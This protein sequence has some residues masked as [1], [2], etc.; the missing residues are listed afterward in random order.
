MLKTVIYY[1]IL[2]FFIIDS[3]L[4]IFLLSRKIIKKIQSNIKREKRDLFVDRIEKYLHQNGKMKISKNLSRFEMNLMEEIIFE[5]LTYSK[6]DMK[7]AIIEVAY[8]SGIVEKQMHE[9]KKRNWWSQ[10]TAAHRLG[11]LKYENAVPILLEKLESK[12]KEI[13]FKSGEAIIRITGA[14]HLEYV[15]KCLTNN[16]QKNYKRILDMIDGINQD[17]YSV[18]QKKIDGDCKEYIII[19]L[20]ALAKRKDYRIVPY[21]KKYLSNE[22]K[23]IRIAALKAS[24][25]IGD[26]GDFEYTKMILNK[27]NDYSWEVRSFLAR[28]L[29]NFRNIDSTKILVK[30][31]KD[32]RWRVRY[33]AGNSLAIHGENG[34]FMLSCM[35]FSDD[36]FAQDMA[37][38]VLQKELMFNQLAIDGL[39]N[40][41]LLEKAYSNIEKYKLTRSVGGDCELANNI[42]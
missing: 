21:I 17:I 6:G 3:L 19:G 38:Q 42:N 24:N 34:I 15:I 2:V 9:I 4:F 33:N 5:Y 11:I 25:E 16:E 37:W 27:Y 35:L 23:E 1:T 31:M 29:S 28:A 10:A 26:I 14:Q 39:G 8:E 22:D 20:E 30:L 36:K 13:Q 18:L 41:S 12:N 40:K 7:Q 32:S